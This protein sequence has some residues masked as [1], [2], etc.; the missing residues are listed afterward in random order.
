M[1]A[2]ELLLE[3]GVVLVEDVA[4][5]SLLAKPLV[6]PVWLRELLALVD[7]DDVADVFALFAD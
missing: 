1:L 2:T 6:L 5:V 4:E 3:D 7:G